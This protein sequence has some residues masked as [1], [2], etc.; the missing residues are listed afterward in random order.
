MLPFSPQQIIRVARMLVEA[1][2][3][4]HVSVTALQR[5]R[6]KRFFE[7]ALHQLNTQSLSER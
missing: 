6:V 1:L 2:D 3:A 7:T 5:E 4:T